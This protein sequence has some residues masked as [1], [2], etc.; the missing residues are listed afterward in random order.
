[1]F[2]NP[3]F[4]QS[5]TMSIRSPKMYIT[6]QLDVVLLRNMK[7]KHS[8]LFCLNLAIAI[9]IDEVDAMANLHG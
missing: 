5:L 6:F 7:C 8:G 3:W 9:S 4:C 1:M 2:T